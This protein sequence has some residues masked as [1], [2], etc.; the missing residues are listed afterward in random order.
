MASAGL[1]YLTLR[2]HSGEGLVARFRGVVLVMGRP[3]TLQTAAL[4]ELLHICETAGAPDTSTRRVARNVTRLIFNAESDETPPF[5]LLAETESGLA[6]VAQGDVTVEIE[7]PSSSERLLGAQVA[8]LV[9]RII[10]GPIGRVN[11]ATTANAP[12]SPGWVDLRFGVVAGSGASLATRDIGKLVPSVNDENR[13]V[14]GGARREKRDAVDWDKVKLVD[15]FGEDMADQQR[16]APPRI[17]EDSASAVGQAQV[18]V[19]GKLCR[20]G[21]LN[22]PNARYC[23]V[24]GVAIVETPVEIEGVRPS[25]G[26]IVFDDRTFAL[27]ADYV[28]GRSPE[29]HSVVKA[30]EA[31]PIALD[32]PTVS[33][34]HVQLHLEGWDVQVSDLTS[35][36]GTSVFFPDERAWRRLPPNVQISLPLVLRSKW[37]RKP[38]FSKAII[39]FEMRSRVVLRARRGFV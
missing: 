23:A 20:R 5:C 3:D 37:V 32:D 4:A 35:R 9:E 18:L 12:R 6:A 17:E 11:I 22:H 2:V 25:L 33:R 13:I 29:D 10:P 31:R 1:D 36:N 8:T 7:T 38:S 34:C 27:T 19:K 28:I 26:V 21:H 24:D 15:L 14:L 16:V 39:N 30:G